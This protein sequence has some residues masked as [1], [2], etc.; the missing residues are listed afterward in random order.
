MDIVATSAGMTA[1]G[2]ENARKAFQAARQFEA[3]LLNS[4]LESLQKS[5]VELPG[6]RE[7]PDTSQ[8]EHLGMQA[9]AGALANDGGI[10]I[11][12]LIAHSLLKTQE[13]KR[14]ANAKVSPH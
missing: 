13:K 11:A 8:Y 3:I 1:S 10:G 12:P 14:I 9:L 6:T 5:F 7:D 4:V 2:A